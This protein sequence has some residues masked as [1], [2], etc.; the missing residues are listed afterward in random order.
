[1]TDRVHHFIDSWFETNIAGRKLRSGVTVESLRKRCIRDAKLEGISLEDLTAV[2]VD[3]EE[4]IAVELN[5]KERD[6]A[7]G[8]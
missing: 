7:A 1:M 6:E 2:V 3:L 8:G 4:A 5:I